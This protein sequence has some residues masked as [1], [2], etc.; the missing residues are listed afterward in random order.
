MNKKSPIITYIMFSICLLWHIVDGYGQTNDKSNVVIK[1]NNIERQGNDFLINV[2]FDL[3][4]LDLGSREQLTLKPVL[5][6]GT[7]I[8]ELPPIIINGKIR[9]KVYLRHQAFENTPVEYRNAQIIKLHPNTKQNFIPY[10]ITI[11]FEEWMNT[12]SLYVKELGCQGCGS[13]RTESSKL[14]LNNPPANDTNQPKYIPNPQVTFVMPDENYSKIRVNKESAYLKF[15]SSSSIINPSFK[16]NAEELDKVSKFI[17]NLIYDKYISISKISIEGLASIEGTYSINM[18]LSEKRAKAF[19]AYIQ[20]KYQ[21]PPSLFETSWIGEDWDGLRLLVENGN[22]PQKERILEIINSTDIFDGRE[23]QLML[24]DGGD[25]YR[26]MFSDYFPLLRKVNYTIEYMVKTFNSVESLEILKTQ[27]SYLSP[28]E[29]FAIAEK[30]DK[31]SDEFKNIMDIAVSTYPTDNVVNINA[32]ATYIIRSKYDV[33]EHYLMSAGNSAPT[34]N[35][36]GVILM[37]RGRYSEAKELLLK[38]K[39]L[40]SED[41]DHNLAELEKIGYTNN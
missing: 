30:Y 34:F 23:K 24:L 41:A 17:E 39:Q 18:Y 6:Q 38:A 14:L 25:P 9:H 12:A 8:I 26:F 36:R 22:M 19:E 29:L 21:L 2:D 33:A 32:A 20:N 31:L 10:I 35:N 13:P 16:N 3:S 28:K 15:P 4:K 37:M 27:P 40:G 1:V 11:P 5:K 7:N